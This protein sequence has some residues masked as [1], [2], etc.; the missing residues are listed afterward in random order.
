MIASFLVL[1]G[2]PLIRGESQKEMLHPVEDGG[3]RVARANGDDLRP[4]RPE[5][6]RYADWIKL[7]PLS[8]R[9]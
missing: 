8:E 3:L 6:G 5:F 9:I 1:A 4:S 7:L 2:A